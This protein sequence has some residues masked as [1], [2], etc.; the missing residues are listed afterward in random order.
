VTQFNRNKHLTF[1]TGYEYYGQ[2]LHEGQDQSF[3]PTPAMMQ[4]DLSLTTIASALNVDS[5]AMLA[6]CSGP[7]SVNE[8]FSNLGG[9]GVSPGWNSTASSAPFNEVSFGKANFGTVASGGNGTGALSAA[10]LGATACNSG[11][12]F[13][14]PA[15]TSTVT[16]YASA[17]PYQSGSTTKTLAC[18]TLGTYPCSQTAFKVNVTVK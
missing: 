9:V 16:I 17:D 10:L 4:G 11:L 5:T 18:S 8:E 14:T 2:H 1:W 12:D 15:G 6:N 7:G 3:V 13:K